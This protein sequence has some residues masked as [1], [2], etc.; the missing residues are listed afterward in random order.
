M[1]WEKEFQISIEES[2][3]KIKGKS[4]LDFDLFDNLIKTASR[5]FYNRVEDEEAQ[6]LEEVINNISVCE[7][8]KELTLREFAD[9]YTWIGSNLRPFLQEFFFEPAYN[10]YKEIDYKTGILYCGEYLVHHTMWLYTEDANWENAIEILNN[11]LHIIEEEDGRKSNRYSQFIF[12]SGMLIE[13]GKKEKAKYLPML[14]VDYSLS[15]SESVVFYRNLC[16]D[17]FAMLMRPL[18]EK[19]RNYWFENY[20]KY[21]TLEIENNQKLGDEKGINSGHYHLGVCYSC[22]YSETGVEDYYIK[23]EKLLK[24]VRGEL[25][26]MAQSELKKLQK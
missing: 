7:K 17:I 2:V 12:N 8:N 26:L 11:C 13:L 15:A 10:L 3:D 16:D 14:M 4:S 25:F 5:N 20:V 6:A 18:S 22:M 24:S 21:K 1:N 19:E 9:V 23:G